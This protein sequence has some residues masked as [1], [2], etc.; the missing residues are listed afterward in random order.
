[1]ALSAPDVAGVEGDGLL[2]MEEILELPEAFLT[3]RRFPGSQSHSHRATRKIPVENLAGKF[4]LDAESVHKAV[5]HTP[6]PNDQ[7]FS[8]STRPMKTS[9]DPRRV[10]MPVGAV[11]H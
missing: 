10:L 9:V 1:L 2:T 3:K 6:L 5:Q 11:R 4:V 7:F 8:T